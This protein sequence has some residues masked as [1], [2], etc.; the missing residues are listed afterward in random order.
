MIEEASVKIENLGDEREVVVGGGGKRFG[1]EKDSPQ[2]PFYKPMGALLL[3][4]ELS[5]C[6]SRA[7]EMLP[8]KHLMKEFF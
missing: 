8:S 4:S 2:S 7:N 3:C 5:Y 6:C 1:E